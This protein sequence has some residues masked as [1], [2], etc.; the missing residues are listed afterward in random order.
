MAEAAAT[1]AKETK[2]PFDHRIYCVW[3]NMQAR[4]YDPTDQHYIDYGA[5]GISVCDDWSTYDAFW[6]WAMAS[7]YARGLSIDRINN[8]GDYTPDNCRWATPR[9]QANNRRSNRRITVAGV[10]LT[11]AQWARVLGISRQA[12]R[13][14]IQRGVPAEW[15]II[16]HIE[17][18]HGEKVAC[19]HMVGLTTTTNSSDAATMAVPNEGG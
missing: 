8:D 10:S 4:C 3:H 2:A 16:A 9:E 13:A 6:A 5:R 7:G 19:R 15:Y 11:H 14:A 1:A 18:G 17:A 12:I